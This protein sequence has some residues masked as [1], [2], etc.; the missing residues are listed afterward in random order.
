V[1]ISIDL[2]IGQF[3]AEDKGTRITVSR[4]FNGV[5]LSAWYS[6]TDTSLF[7]DQF[8]KGYHEYGIGLTI[9]LRMFSG[10]DSRTSYSYAISPWTRDVAQDINHY[11]NLFDF[12]GGRIRR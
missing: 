12:I 8:N 1:D 2:K 5:I 7:T 11:N 4:S 6:L 9:P 3:L 10:G